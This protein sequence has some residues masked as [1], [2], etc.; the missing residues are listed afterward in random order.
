MAVAWLVLWR[1]GEVRG[2]DGARLGGA[3][4]RWST[5][6]GC[7]AS[8]F[9]AAHTAAP[10]AE[11]PS[12]LLLLG[13]PGG[14]FGY[15]ALPLLVVAVF[16][17]LRRRPPV[18]RAVRVLAAIAVMTV[19]AGVAVLADRARV[20]DALPRGRAR[21]G[22]ARAGLG[23]LARRALDGARAGRRRGRVADERA[24]ADQEQRADGLDR[25][26][27]VRSAPATSSIATQPEQVPALYRYLP[28][29]VVYRTPMGLV[30]DPRQTDW[31]DGLARL[32]AGQA[33]TRA[34]ARRRRG[35]TAASAC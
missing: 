20:G 25:R 31:R 27:A 6:R 10:W 16:F 28:E 8:L 33:E 5:R 4:S 35:W 11:R 23:R 15:V 19:V 22:A 29:G 7:R 18:D 21:A 13:F 2:G 24:A 14:L 9:Q 12:P 26:R 17:A 34:A 32:R 3:R 30:L 1:R